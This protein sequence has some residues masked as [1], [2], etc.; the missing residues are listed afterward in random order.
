MRSP[1][2]EFRNDGLRDSLTQSPAPSI[3]LTALERE[4]ES[5]QRDRRSLTIISFVSA[6]PATIHADISALARALKKTCRTAEPYSRISEDGFWVLIK[7][8]HDG[9]E[10]FV[11][12]VY[13]EPELFLMEPVKRWQSKIIEHKPNETLDEWIARIDRAHFQW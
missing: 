11:E 4:F 10:K 5:A 12:R 9:A 3:F 6:S 7:G 13:S 1:L 8:G 2:I